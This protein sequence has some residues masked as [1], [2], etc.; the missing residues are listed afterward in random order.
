MSKILIFL[1]CVT[2]F[3]VVSTLTAVFVYKARR[4]RIQGKSHGDRTLGPT[5]VS[6]PHI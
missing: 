3:V 4:K 1:I 5:K 2:I 6:R